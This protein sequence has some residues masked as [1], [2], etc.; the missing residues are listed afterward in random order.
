M[1]S[2]WVLILRISYRLKTRYFIFFIE[3]ESGTNS[4]IVYYILTYTL[5]LQPSSLKVCRIL[6]ETRSNIQLSACIQL[7]Q[8]LPVVSDFSSIGCSRLGNYSIGYSFRI[9]KSY[10]RYSLEVNSPLIWKNIFIWWS[11]HVSMK[12]FKERKLLKLHCD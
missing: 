2:Q 5:Y 12:N 8:L 11:V 1:K 9:S 4:S 6:W 7:S 10:S 3:S